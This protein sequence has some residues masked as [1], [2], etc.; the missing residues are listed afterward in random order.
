MTPA[1][2]AKLRPMRMASYSASLLV[3]ENWSRT[4]HSIISTSGD[5]RTASMPPAHLLN[6][7][8]I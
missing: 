1:A 2:L 6:D 7:P 4:A 3:I 5:W 8:S